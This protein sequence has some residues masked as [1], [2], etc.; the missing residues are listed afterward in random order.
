MCEMT[1]VARTR[2]QLRSLNHNL[3]IRGCASL[4]ACGLVCRSSLGSF[5]DLFLREL[6]LIMIVIEH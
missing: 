2:M 3:V 5:V 1:R 6:W 4:P